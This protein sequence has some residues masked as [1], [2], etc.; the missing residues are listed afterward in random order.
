MKLPDE[1][2]IVHV[3]VQDADILSDWRW[4]IGSTARLLIVSSLGDAF[5]EDQASVYWLNVGDGIYVK[6]ADSVAGFESILAS[7]DKVAEWFIPELVLDIQRLGITRSQHQCFSFKKPPVLG[8][9]YEPENFEAAD[10]S[11]HFSLLGQIHEQV[12]DLPAGTS[13]SEFKIK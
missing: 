8:G 5:L 9:K 7:P 3:S 12:K 1:A 4:L 13:I 11:I 2:L 10:I 6:V